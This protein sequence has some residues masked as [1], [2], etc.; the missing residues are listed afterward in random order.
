MKIIELFEREDPPM[1]RINPRN[2][3][4]LKKIK[5]RHPQA[6]SELD[7]LIAD[8]HTGQRQDRRDITRLGNENEQEQAEIDRLDQEN[9]R[10]ESRLDQ[11]EQELEAIK[12]MIQQ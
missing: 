12:R 3:L 5:A 10:D 8:L 6:K 9:D 7:A 1:G 11:V 4:I 2:A